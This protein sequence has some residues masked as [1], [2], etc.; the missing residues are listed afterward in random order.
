M[1]EA[2]P[3]SD[4]GDSVELGE[5]FRLRKLLMN[6]HRVYTFQIGEHYQL[7]QRS[8]VANVAFLVRVDLSPFAGRHPKQGDI[9]QVGFIGIDGVDAGFIEAG[10]DKFLFDRVGVNPIVDFGKCSLEVPIPVNPID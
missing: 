10:W 8:K 1:S 4:F 2:C 6:Q 7:F 3:A 5:A 9:Q